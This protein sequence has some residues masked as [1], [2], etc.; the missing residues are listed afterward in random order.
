M[1]PGDLQW[2]AFGPHGFPLSELVEVW[3]DGGTIVGWGFLESQ[4]GY[5]WQVLPELRGSSVDAEIAR[6]AHDATLR[7]RGENNLDA[8]CGTE[9]FADDGLRI[10]ILEAMGYRQH[11]AEFV[12]FK[13]ALGDIPA[14]SLPEG[15]AARA[16]TEVDIDSRATCQYEAFSPGSRTTPQT[17][18]AMMASAPGYRQA[19]DTVVVTPEGVVAAAAMCWLDERNRIGLFE[20]VATR[21]AYQR[22]GVGKAL[23]LQGLRALAARGMTQAFVGT[24]ASNTAA[25][26]LYTSVGFQPRNHGYEMEWRPG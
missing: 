9:V 25:R 13:R 24:N 12:A 10:A 11:G 16:I 5:S 2:R 3:E 14:P 6:W 8:S 21:P 22:R 26:A 20:P 17:W 18:R 15:W 23:M 19:L 4:A 1:H 7:W